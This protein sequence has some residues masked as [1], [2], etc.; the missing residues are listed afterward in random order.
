MQS[1][2][3]CVQN[4]EKNHKAVGH[5][6]VSTLD[7][8]WAV[9]NGAKA[10]KVPVIIGASEGERDFMGASAVRALV[11]Q[12]K[13]DNPEREIFLNADHTYSLDRAKE[14]ID[15]GY[16]SVVIDGAK[17][18][19]EENV[20]LTKKVVEYAKLNGS[21]TLVEGELGYI[22]QSSKVLKELPKGAAVTGA[23]MTT[24]EHAFEFAKETG[25]AMLAPAVGS[26]H[27]MLATGHDPNLNIE[28]IKE[29]KAALEISL[30]LHG[31][32]GLTTQNFVKGIEAGIA[33][34]HISTEL[35]VAW[36]QALK[37]SLQENADEVAPYKMLK[38]AQQAV[39][40]VV[41]EKLKLFNNLN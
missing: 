12:I 13:K 32:S 29:I 4:A 30:V 14:V 40:K 9:V 16:D 23:D 6:N 27:G 10:L 11:N 8:V 17:L 39:Q 5:F 2:L 1:L 7:M 15:L 35:R 33:L 31:G 19:W 34:V 28:R 37:I 26:I 25:I 18:S 24:A 22:G 38:P 41:E 20:T 36:C 3:Q 21:H